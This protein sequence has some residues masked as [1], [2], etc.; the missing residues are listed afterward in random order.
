M[1]VLSPDVSISECVVAG[2]VGVGGYF[3]C[4]FGVGVLCLAGG[5]WRP[6]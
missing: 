6:F 3:G 4:I 2:G 1:E 5:D